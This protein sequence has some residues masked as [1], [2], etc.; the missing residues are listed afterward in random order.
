MFEPVSSCRGLDNVA[1]IGLDDVI[2][3]GSDEI[4]ALVSGSDAGVLRALVPDKGVSSTSGM[5]EYITRFLMLSTCL[6]LVVPSCNWIMQD[7]G[8]VTSATEPGNH[9][10]DFPV[11]FSAKTTSPTVKVR[12]GLE[13]LWDSFCLACLFPTF[14]DRSGRKLSKRERGRRPTS[15]S[16]GAMPVVEWGIK[17]FVNRNLDSLSWIWRSCIHSIALWTAR[18][19]KPLVEGW[20]GVDVT[21]WMPFLSMNWRNSTLVKLGTLLVTIFCGNPW[22]EKITQSFSIVLL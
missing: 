18:S 2:P 9:L 4:S 19:A 7:R 20:Y 13:L 3:I 14:S 5:S 21:W 22:V 15:S 6:C 8:P 17:W 16:A 1:T 11:K 10:G 12:V